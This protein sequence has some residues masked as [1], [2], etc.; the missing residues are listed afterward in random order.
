MMF[1]F[2]CLL[3]TSC[4]VPSASVIGEAMSAIAVMNAVQ[5]KFGRDNIL[6]IVEN[7][8]NYIRYIKNI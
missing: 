8:K 3:Y 6:E 1:L 2:L 5:D 7:Y 4:A